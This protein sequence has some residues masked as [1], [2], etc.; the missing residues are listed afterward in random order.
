MIPKSARYDPSSVLG[1]N[2]PFNIVVG[3]RTYGK[4]YGWI[5]YCTKN[6]L[7][8]GETFAFMR[9]YEQEVKDILSKPE[10]FFQNMEKEFPKHEL[11]VNGHMRRRTKR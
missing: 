5:K 2:C 4:T 3:A 6:Y 11:R 1:S 8:T 9:T 7:K 10:P